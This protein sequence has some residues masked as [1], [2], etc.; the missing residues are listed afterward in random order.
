MTARVQAMVAAFVKMPSHMKAYVWQAMV[1]AFVK[2]P[3]YHMLRALLG[4]PPT[5]RLHLFWLRWS[6]VLTIAA[7]VLAVSFVVYV[8]CKISTNNIGVFDARTHAKDAVL[9]IDQWRWA[10]QEK[11]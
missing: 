3:F 4:A 10:E 2:S 5:M 8:A 11:N 6:T 1:A 7:M 9:R